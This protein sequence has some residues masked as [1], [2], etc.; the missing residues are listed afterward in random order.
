MTTGE[1]AIF[2]SA[3][4]RNRLLRHFLQDWP[5]GLWP[6]DAAHLDLAARIASEGWRERAAERGLPVPA[7]TSGAC[8]FT[9][10]FG[11]HLFGGRILGNYDHQHLVL[12][13]GRRWDP[14]AENA[15]VRALLERGVDPWRQGRKGFGGRDHLE[16][17]ASCLPRVALWIER[18]ARLAPQEAAPEPF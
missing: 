16:G 7:D 11:L 1:P 6:A 14:C 9:S 15:D 13:D 5:P 4:V 2:P 17:M 8:V 18:F 3:P 12:P 10:L